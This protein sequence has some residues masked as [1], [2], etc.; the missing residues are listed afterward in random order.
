[1]VLTETIDQIAWREREREGERRRV[2]EVERLVGDVRIRKTRNCR[3]DT[4]PHE[5]L[6]SYF[7]SFFLLPCT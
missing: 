6:T 7:S 3:S 2:D 1:M 4:D 5:S